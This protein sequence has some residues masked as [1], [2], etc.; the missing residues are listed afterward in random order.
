MVIAAFAGSAAHSQ[1]FEGN[2]AIEHRFTSDVGRVA[3][4][5]SHGLA[6]VTLPSQGLVKVIST[7]TGQFIQD[8]PISGAPREIKISAD[9]QTAL[10]GS[11]LN[12]VSIDLSSMSTTTTPIGGL[13]GTEFA[14]AIN[15][16]TQ[17]SPSKMYISAELNGVGHYNT[18]V[19]YDLDTNEVFASPLSIGGEG[20]LNGSPSSPYFMSVYSTSPPSFQ[21]GMVDDPDG[22]LDYSY[23]N[24]SA[25]WSAYFQDG[26]RVLLGNG[27][28]RSM[29]EF[30]LLADVSGNV[31]WGMTL[32]NQANTYAYGI[33]RG[34]LFIADM[35]ALE[36]I[37]EIDVPFG[38]GENYGFELINSDTGYMALYSRKL[39]LSIPAPAAGMSWLVAGLLAKRRRRSVNS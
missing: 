2:D 9:G 19:S 37:A 30:E 3:Y 36:Q 8:I 34:N 22:A 10:V 7:R 27:E 13:F 16:I 33:R 4:S 1:L 11:W 35:S 6:L 17:V 15:S 20:R 28:I 21:L 26:E 39:V 14:R 29:P 5:S 25:G 32:L 12:L 38:G 24:I 31:S 18:I 23:R